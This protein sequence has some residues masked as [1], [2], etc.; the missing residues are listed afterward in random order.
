MGQ[1]DRV[2]ELFSGVLDILHGE[3]FVD[4]TARVPPDDCP[5]RHAAVGVRVVAANAGQDEGEAEFGGGVSGQVFVRQEYHLVAPL[6]QEVR[7]HGG[8]I[9]RGTAVIRLGLD[10]RVSIHIGDDGRARIPFFQVAHVLCGDT[11]CEGTPGLLGGDE[12]GLVRIQGLGGLGHEQD[13]AEDDD[14]GA[15]FG[16]DT[17]QLERV[18]HII[19]HAM[20]QGGF[21][22]IVA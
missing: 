19:G 17:G 8:G 9:S 18:A 5:V 4:L 1:D 6:V 22:V 11:F 14:V 2:G 3:Q 7:Y 20:I 10:V 21:H 12:D 15:G 16:G 13:A